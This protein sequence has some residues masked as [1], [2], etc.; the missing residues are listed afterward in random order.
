MKHI[1]RDIPT[2]LE[3]PVYE[4]VPDHPYTPFKMKINGFYQKLRTIFK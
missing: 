3:H 4:G 1:F 2:I